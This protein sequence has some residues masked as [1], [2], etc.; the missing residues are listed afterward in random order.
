MKPD[1]KK[2]YDE[3][4]IAWHDMKVHGPAS[5]WLRS[6]INDQFKRINSKEVHTILDL[7][8]GEGTITYEIAK[9][10]S[11]AQ[12]TGTDFSITG[13]E[14]AEKKYILPNLVFKH[15]ND[16]ANL[17]LSYDM[18]TCF[19]V[20][21]HVE[22]W[23]ELLGRMAESSTK[24]LLLSFPTG[25]M[26]PFEVNVGH[27]RNFQKKQVEDFLKK[28]NFYPQNIFYSGFPFYSPLYRDLCNIT[29][30]GS[31]TFTKGTYGFS[32]KAVA[33]VLY[34]L[35]RHLS[36]RKSYGDQ[37]CGLFTKSA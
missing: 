31:N 36:S 18:I 33:S 20:L 15:D 4:W 25:R 32:Q 10:F 21:E 35:F 3:N 16:S 19:E 5:R 1:N 28:Y 34:F 30:S 7:G 9:Q 24:Y 29:N 12:V 6:L 17:N 26:R 2:I 37:F 14:F 23:E 8:C 11:T 27:F 13:I 22:H